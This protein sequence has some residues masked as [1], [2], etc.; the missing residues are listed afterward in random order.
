MA[1]EAK[2]LYVLQGTNG[3]PSQKGQPIA[4]EISLMSVNDKETL[5]ADDV[6]EDQSFVGDET[7]FF[8]LVPSSSLYIVVAHDQIEPVLLCKCVKQV[9]D[10][11]IRTPHI[12]EPTILPQLVAIA[13]FNVHKPMAVIVAQCIEVETTVSRESIRSTVVSTMAV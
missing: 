11:P 7:V 10:S 6:L 1:R 8:H 12:A 13:H 3:S 9:K 5:P 4:L 2:P